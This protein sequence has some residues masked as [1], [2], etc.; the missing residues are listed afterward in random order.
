MFTKLAQSLLTSYDRRQEFNRKHLPWLL[1]LQSFVIHKVGEHSKL[2]TRLCF[3]IASICM[4]LFT[5]STIHYEKPWG[6]SAVLGCL[7]LACLLSL[8]FRKK[9]VARDDRVAT[10]ANGLRFVS[11]ATLLIVIG[12]I[13]TERESADHR[14]MEAAEHEEKSALLKE[15]LAEGRE[16][17]AALLKEKLAENDRLF[18][19]VSFKAEYSRLSAPKIMFECK[20][21]TRYLAGT[22]LQ[23]YNALLREAESDCGG[24]FDLLTGEK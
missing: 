15:K 11:F 14:K 20:G 23:N 5:F 9:F 8:S 24:D 4:L 17:K 6:A 22:G 12:M 10:Y 13:P 1:D 3:L 19:E 21:S 16:E 7:M 18:R 2:L